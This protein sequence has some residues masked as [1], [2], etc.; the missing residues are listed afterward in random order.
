MKKNDSIIEYVKERKNK[1]KE[2]FE[3]KNQYFLNRD[4]HY[5]D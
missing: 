1:I 4:I 2:L 3:Y 5:I